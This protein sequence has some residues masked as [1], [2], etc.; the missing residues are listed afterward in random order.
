MDGEVMGGHW[1]TYTATVTR[2]D[3]L[4][5]AVVA[6]LNPAATDVEHF[7]EVEPAVRDLIGGLTDSDPEAGEFWIRWKFVQNG[8]DYTPMI[9]QLEA[10]E[11]EANRA[12]AVRD[13]ARRAAIQSMR[14]SGLSLRDIADVMGISHQRVHQ[15]AAEPRHMPVPR[16][17]RR[18]LR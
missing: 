5:V 13:A 12:I 18:D 9:E 3:A 17:A 16:K 6:E 8:H 11:L 14:R 7:D 1:P 10:A 15:L 2:E 4:W